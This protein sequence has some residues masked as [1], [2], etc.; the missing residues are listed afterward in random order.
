MRPIYF[1]KPILCKG[2]QI[3][4]IRK[5]FK[6]KYHIS[7]NLSQSVLY[8]RSWQGYY[9]HLTEDSQIL[10]GFGGPTWANLHISFKDFLKLENINFI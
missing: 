3:P 8:K 10:I 2:Y 1:T 5:F 7:T 4:F 6:R 9:V